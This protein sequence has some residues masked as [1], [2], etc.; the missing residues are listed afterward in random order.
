MKK[1]E[2]KNKLSEL[3]LE[4]EKKK[5]QKKKITKQLSIIKEAGKKRVHCLCRTRISKNGKCKFESLCNARLLSYKGESEKH[6][7]YFSDFKNASFYE[8]KVTCRICKR[9]M[10]PYAYKCRECDCEF[11]NKKRN[12][13]RQLW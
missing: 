11:D 12:R 2:L 10:R 9:N 6:S 7:I 3:N 4:I 13:M 5:E 1:E 8:S